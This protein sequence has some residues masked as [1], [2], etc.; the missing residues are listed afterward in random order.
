M[1]HIFFKLKKW[2]SIEVGKSMIKHK[3]EKNINCQTYGKQE[4]HKLICI[5]D[6]IEGHFRYRGGHSL[7]NLD[8]YPLKETFVELDIT[9]IIQ[10]G[11]IRP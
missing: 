5:R 2:G 8:S 4:R 11:V 1:L 10:A 6:V 3:I 7:T 9:G